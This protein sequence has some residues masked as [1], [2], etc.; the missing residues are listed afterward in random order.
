MN[1]ASVLSQVCVYHVFF[2]L[3]PRDC[4]KI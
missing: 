3:N 2:K 1:Q 4:N